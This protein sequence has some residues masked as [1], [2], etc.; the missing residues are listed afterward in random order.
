MLVRDYIPSVYVDL[1]YASKDNF[2]GTA[3]YDFTD[4]YLRY[5]TVKKLAEV[6][7]ELLEQGYSLKI[8]DAYRLVSAQFR[9][10]APTQL[11][12]PIQ[13]RG[14]PVTAGETRWT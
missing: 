2:T 6:Q 13:T 9:R 5:G 4:A 14:I 1:K 12:L 7:Q 8:W 3:I 11:T 10:S